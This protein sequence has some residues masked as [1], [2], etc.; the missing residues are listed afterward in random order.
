MLGLKTTTIRSAA[1]VAGNKRELSAAEA[2]LK[3]KIELLKTERTCKICMDDE[4]N[5]LFLPCGHLV[6]CSECSKTVSKCCICKKTIK[7]II[8]VYS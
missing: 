3:R 5:M 1:T 4:S 7:R 6:T 2:D 8:R